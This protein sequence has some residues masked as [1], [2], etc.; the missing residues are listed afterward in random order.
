MFLLRF[1]QT[2]QLCKDIVFQEA[3]IFLPIRN[4][5]EHFHVLLKVVFFFLPQSLS[6]HYITALLSLSVVNCVCALFSSPA[7]LILL[8][9]YF[10]LPCLVL[11]LDQILNLLYACV[12]ACVYHRCTEGLMPCS[13]VYWENNRAAAVTTKSRHV[14]QLIWTELLNMC[15][16]RCTESVY[17]TLYLWVGWFKNRFEAITNLSL[18]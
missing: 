10:F 15:S 13:I 14:F 7:H 6:E 17:Q 1:H 18:K 11:F 4:E 5:R 8:N 16:H 9:K 12:H 3:F 2:G